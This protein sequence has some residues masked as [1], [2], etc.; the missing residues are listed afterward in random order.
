MV[1]T[2]GIEEEFLLTDARTGLPTGS[3]ELA[4]A[5]MSPEHG[6]LPSS[7]ELLDAQVEVSTP[8]CTTRDEA[9]QALLAFR[10][11]LATA[12][13]SVGVR[14]AP[15]GAAPNIPDAPPVLNS[16]DRYRRM[17]LLTG[18]VAR[19]QYVNGVHVHVGIDSRDT[20]VRVLNGLRPWLALLG[21][22]AANSPY[23]RGSDSSFASWRMVH[24]RRWSVQGCP[25]LFSDAL[26]YARRL[27][28]LLLATD[29]VPD[30]GHVG[31][32]ARL[33]EHFP[34]VEVRIADAQLQAGDTVL[35]AVLVRALV[36]TLASAE[37]ASGAAPDPELLDVG[38][39]QA[40]RFG[41]GGNLVSY[42][43]GSVPAA[44]LLHALLD[45][46]ADALEDAGDGEFAAAGIAR[47]L[48]TGT[49]A[50]RQRAAFHSGGPAGLVDLYSRSLTAQ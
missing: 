10:S 17:G 22:L 9:L 5:L 4:R 14:V 38:L 23:W 45:Y 42:P 50:Q 48:A 33:S 25:P 18:A 1:F 3:R 24:Y 49:G 35:L 28:A 8:V 31:W 44:E 11:G 15:T 40:A 43:G 20:G 16:S 39:W 13:A 12:A 19:E 47:I 41:L 27:D 2:F 37:P 36:K 30:A 46:V 34:T 29:V 26:D 6:S 7:A 21:A 32:A